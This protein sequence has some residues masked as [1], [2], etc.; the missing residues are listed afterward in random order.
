MSEGEGA[1]SEAV[2]LRESSLEA[3]RALRSDCSVDKL[4]HC[5]DELRNSTV[6][7]VEN[8]LKWKR[9]KEKRPSGGKPRQLSLQDHFQW[10]GVDYV[11]KMK[12]DTDWFLESPLSAV[13]PPDTPKRSNPFL[14]CR[15]EYPDNDFM[16]SENRELH[17]ILVAHKA[18]QRQTRVLKRNTADSAEADSSRS[19]ALTAASTNSNHESGR[20]RLASSLSPS[21]R[22]SA[23]AK[24]E[25]GG[26]RSPKLVTKHGLSAKSPGRRVTTPTT[27]AATAATAAVAAASV[28]Q[29]AVLLPVS[30]CGKEGS[31][32]MVLGGTGCC[33]EM[34]DI[35]RFSSILGRDWHVMKV[36][37]N[38]ITLSDNFRSGVKSAPREAWHRA[39]VMRP[40]SKDEREFWLKEWEDGRVT[41]ELEHNPGKKDR[42][43]CRFGVQVSDA[44]LERA[45]ADPAPGPLLRGA[46]A[47][48]RPH[49][50]VDA[51]RSIIA[52]E[53]SRCLNI[54][55]NAILP[56]SCSTIAL[57]TWLLVSDGSNGVL[58]ITKD[59]NT[60]LFVTAAGERSGA[61][62]TRASW[63][64]FV[65]SLAIEHGCTVLK[66]VEQ[67]LLR[68]HC[69]RFATWREAKKLAMALELPR[70][71]ARI[72]MQRWWRRHHE[73]RRIWA[74]TA[75]QALHRGS[76]SRKRTAALR[77]SIRRQK[78]RSER[79]SA[80]GKIQ[81]W[82]IGVRPV[83]AWCVGEARER[84]IA[85]QKEA[86]ERR[87][88]GRKRKILR[89]RSTLLRTSVILGGETVAVTIMTASGR[90]WRS[91]RK[92]DL[93]L[94]LYIPRTQQTFEFVLDEIK[95]RELMGPGARGFSLG[96]I[97]SVDALRRVI[98][99]MQCRKAADE[100]CSSNQMDIKLA[101]L[102]AS[103]RGTLVH[104]EARNLQGRRYFIRIFATPG[105]L[106][107][108]AYDSSDC[109]TLRTTISYCMLKS[110]VDWE[111]DTAVDH[112][113]R[114]VSRR[115]KQA[116][117]LRKLNEVGGLTVPE[118]KLEAAAR[119]LGVVEQLEPATDSD[120]EIVSVPLEVL[121]LQAPYRGYAD[122][123]R[124][125]G[126]TRHFPWE[127]SGANTK[128][129]D[130]AAPCLQPPRLESLSHLLQHRRKE[131]MRWILPRL[132]VECSPS[133]LLATAHE[134]HGHKL[135]LAA[136][137]IHGLWKIR[138][139]RDRCRNLV[140][141]QWER[142]LLDGTGE[143]IYFHV[144]SQTVSRRKPRALRPEDSLPDP[145]GG[146]IK[147]DDGSFYNPVTGAVTG[148]SVSA[149]R[150]RLQ[151]WGR[152]VSLPHLLP[153]PSLDQIA[154]GRRLYMSAEEN[155]TEHPDRLSSIL[156][157]AM[158]LHCHMGDLEAARPL[159]E[160]A[161]HLS[162]DNPL[163]QR[164]MA[165]FLLMTCQFPR[166][167]TSA[168]AADLLHAAAYRDG[169][170]SKF[171]MARE[172]IYAYALVLHG[173]SNARALLAWAIMLEWVDQDYQ[174]AESFYRRA[175]AANPQDHL[176]R[177]NAKDFYLKRL[178]GTGPGEPVR[179]RSTVI[180]NT[181]QPDSEPDWVLM[182]DPQPLT[183]RL[184]EFWAHTVTLRTSWG[185]P[186]HSTGST[187]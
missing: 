76:L 2:E 142:R 136:E 143:E 48:W 47:D 118:E 186:M 77:V 79:N 88:Q 104:K 162:G 60:E 132:V 51:F 179:I 10:N 68:I 5:L 52:S 42:H 131:L 101:K 39:W 108:T 61:H 140:L 164:A 96:E 139:A 110:W 29:V 17:R 16:P 135:A 54:A 93:K 95:V 85:C 170:G 28:S 126:E 105:S 123:L 91:V 157:F 40:T 111:R 69:V 84:E 83:A 7:V 149:A 24:A 49:Q 74:A 71:A 160:K 119:L 116:S 141:K 106:S 178:P 23:G 97:C 150:I 112:R 90:D 102:H 144:P 87:I 20:R 137:H 127:S 154:N 32:E 86:E 34:H 94:R 175:L 121:P 122:D 72:C 172:A 21:K 184:T 115:L 35:L 25:R 78:R 146:W 53:D 182:H 98:S 148:L 3:L 174:R 12:H 176:V 55:F 185:A 41:W 125:I 181:K 1:I 187:R 165:L 57:E 8:I 152:R 38:K 36:S 138:R 147:R 124:T 15:L 59:T 81:R 22:D 109:T 14:L 151:Q 120:H 27:T 145:T 103:E 177:Q 4:T 156:N 45:V 153:H 18:L 180:P 113:C 43:R 171:M 80:A 166:D 155:Y 114:E 19:R 73:M 130:F 30:V 82:F 50:R 33:I 89:Q 26:S 128:G 169:S 129:E 66:F 117:K 173:P 65:N 168:T 99:H 100:S 9:E 161:A 64:V 134:H 67:H 56:E 46:A 159:Y 163:V 183:P 11:Q 92:L 75:I 31:A 63:H 44:D 58:T 158:V 62:L 37:A 107:V 6:L 70:L 133:R 167:K 13:L